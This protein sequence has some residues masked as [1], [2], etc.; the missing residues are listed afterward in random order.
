MGADY[1]SKAIIGVRLLIDEEKIPRAKIPV[2][3]RAFK[4][5]YTDDGEMEFHPKDGRKLWLNEKEE[6]EADYPAY[7]YNLDDDVSDLEEGQTLVVFPESLDVA[8]GTDNDSWYLGCAVGTG[9]SNGGDEEGF[10]PIPDINGLKEKLKRTLEPHGLWD[11]SRF[12]LYS[13][14]YCSY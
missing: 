9:S 3:K 10:I 1:Y 6:I 11:E 8:S 2:R 14:L 7:V 12:G 4:H 13:V 5:T